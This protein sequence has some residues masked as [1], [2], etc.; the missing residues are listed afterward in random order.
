LS[1]PSV[2]A[3]GDIIRRRIRG[4][5]TNGL[6][7]SSGSSWTADVLNVSRM[8]AL[9]AKLPCA[10]LKALKSR[11]FSC[12]EDMSRKNGCVGLNPAG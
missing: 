9:G 11:Q 4:G 3:A 6:K 1:K 2:Q 5:T 8:A 10:K 12:A 7:G